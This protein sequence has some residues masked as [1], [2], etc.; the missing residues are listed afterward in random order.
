M[1]EGDLLP[2]EADAQ[3]SWFEELSRAGRALYVEPGLWIAAEHAAEYASPD[4]ARLVRRCLRYRGAQDAGT[5]AQRYALSED[6]AQGHL[7]DL[8]AAGVAVRFEGMYVHAD[9][10]ASA[11]RLTIASRRS[12]VKTAPAAR[13]AYLLA[14]RAQTSGSQKARLAAGISGLLGIELPAASWEEVV[15]PARVPGYRPDM[16]DHLL[17]EGGIVYAIRVSDGKPYVTFRAVEDF[18]FDR[19][20]PVEETLA[21]EERRMLEILEKG[22][23]Q[24]DYVIS[25]RLGGKGAGEAL[26]KLASLGL[27]KQDAFT[28]VRRALNPNPRA[29]NKPSAG[30]WERAHDAREL[31]VDEAIAG[32]FASIPIL[33]RETCRGIPWQAAL[34]R[35]RM[36]E[37]TGEARRGYFAEGLSGAQFVRSEEFPRVTSA[38]AADRT[39]YYCL[40]A[41]DPM[42]AWGRYVRHAPGREFMLVPGTA[43]VTSGGEAVCVFERQGA[44]LRAFGEAA[45][46]VKCFAQAFTSGRIFA[47]RSRITVS[48]YPDEA[49]EWLSEAGFLREALDYVLYAK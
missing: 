18:D 16:L 14:A 13:F 12:E 29:L 44:V 41:V 34:D 10:Y 39:E 26:Q 1:A 40:S 38:L 49:R 33:S 19:F 45:D 4:W 9:V 46:A 3:V 17:A 48:Q 47:G 28:P 31:T 22:G 30:R 32:M 36:M 43:V 6:E 11:Q 8:E 25:K 5:I 20:T 24:F 7:D 42:Q 15:L 35:L 27:V 2:G 23:A 37:L 21:P